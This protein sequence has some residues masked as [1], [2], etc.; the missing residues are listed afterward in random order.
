MAIKVLVVDD[1]SFFRR[2]ICR[3]LESDS[4]IEVV[5]TAVNGKE[6]IEK[7]V[8]LKPDVVTMDVEMP[9][10]DGITAVKHIMEKQ[11]TSIL[12]FSSLTV[13][14]A[15]ATLNAIEAGAVDFIPK[16]FEEIAKNKAEIARVLCERVRAASLHRPKAIRSVLSTISADPALRG[17]SAIP[18]KILHHRSTKTFELVAIGTST[19]G[20]LALQEVLTKLPKNF[21]V[22]ILLIQHMPAT[23]TSAFAQRL[24]QLCQISVCEAQ[25]GQIIQPGTAYLAPGGQQL[26]VAK[27]GGVG[28]IKMF[29]TEEAQTYKP[30]IDL[31]FE[32]LEREYKNRVLAIVLTGMGKDGCEGAKKLKAAGSEIW[33][34][35]E[36]TSVVFGMPHAV[37][38][39]NLTTRVL[40]LQEFSN[41]LIKQFCE[42]K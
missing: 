42:G 41:A 14:G 37:I 35:D 12:M 4:S 8:S 24:D 17:N 21:P 11:P 2:Q 36:E 13:E 25:A 26:G 32:T 15:K 27:R 22:P 18:A 39:E 5:D 3:I 10:M 19:G 28:V 30:C 40:P 7:T 33:A 34:Q 31:T 6:A 1:S 16:K 38:E 23:F 29:E 9:V 20:P